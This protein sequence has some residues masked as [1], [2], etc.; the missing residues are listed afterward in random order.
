M[1]YQIGLTP[2]R[3]RQLRPA[4]YTTV[5]FQAPFLFA[6][7]TLYCCRVIKRIIRQHTGKVERGR[8][9]HPADKPG[10]TRSTWPTVNKHKQHHNAGN[11]PGQ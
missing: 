4:P 8:K 9:K 7:R 5:R 11:D 1:Q 10:P 2:L 6:G 3:P